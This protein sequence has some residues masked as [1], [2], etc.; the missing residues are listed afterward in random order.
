MNIARFDKRIFGWLI[1]EILP[2][3]GGGTLLYF[4]WNYWGTGM[5]LFLIIF[6]SVLGDYFL[7]ILINAITM[8]S[9][10]GATI[11]MAIF[12]IKTVHPEGDKLKMGE[13][14]LKCLLTGVIA[15]DLINAIFMLAVHTERSAFDRMTNTLVVDRRSLNA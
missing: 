2:L 15:M 4:L 1:D 7:Y 8:S 10:R 9:T 11:G 13:C 14:W 5:S 3:L 6:L 12:G